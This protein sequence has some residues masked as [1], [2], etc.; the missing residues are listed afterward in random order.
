MSSGMPRTSMTRM[1]W[2]PSAV[3]VASMASSYGGTPCPRWWDS[4]VSLLVTSSRRGGSHASTRPVASSQRIDVQAELPAGAQVA[5]HLA[6]P[7]GEAPG[8]GECGPQVVDAGAVAVFD[9]HDALASADRRLPRMRVPGRALL[10]M[11]CSFVRVSPGYLGVQGVQPLLPQGPVLAQPFIDLG[12]RLGAKA[13]DP[14]LRFLA[15]LDQPC[16]P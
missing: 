4:S 5:L 9:A 10:V 2:S 15:D 1:V 7:A 3:S 16:L 11:W 14:A 6:V 12:E 13:V 8:I